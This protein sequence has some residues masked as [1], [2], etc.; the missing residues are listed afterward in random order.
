MKK[1]LNVIVLILAVL[2]TAHFVPVYQRLGYLD[3]E[4]GNLCIAYN[5]PNVYS[6][7]V[8]LH[9]FNTPQYFKADSQAANGNNSGV[10]AEPVLLRYYLI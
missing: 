8:I 7:R 1:K 2:I 9:G 5:S 10:C 4:F 3:R 6:N